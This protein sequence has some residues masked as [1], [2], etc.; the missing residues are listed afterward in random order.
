L[1]EFRK[2]GGF[3][4]EEAAALFD[5]LEGRPDRASKSLETLYAARGELRLRNLALGALHATLGP[6]ISP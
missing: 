3:G 4:A 1:V 2:V 6:S 5:L